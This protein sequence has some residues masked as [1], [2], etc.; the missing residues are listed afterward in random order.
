[1]DDPLRRGLQEAHIHRCAVWTTLTFL[2]NFLN[3]LSETNMACAYT[4]FLDALQA[5]QFTFPGGFCGMAQ[6]VM[7]ELGL[8]R[9][10]FGK[11]RREWAA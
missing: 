7:E 1:M 10:R 8:D 4:A 9:S 11:P 2:A 3:G 6:V 5:S